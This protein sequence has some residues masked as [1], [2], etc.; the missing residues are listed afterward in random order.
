MPEGGLFHDEGE[1]TITTTQYSNTVDTWN[2][3][4]EEC[5][6]ELAFQ[7]QI[8]NFSGLGSVKCELQTAIGTTEPAE[9]SA[10]WQTIE[11]VPEKHEIDEDP[12]LGKT[13]FYINQFGRYLRVK[14]TIIGTPTVTLTIKYQTKGT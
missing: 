11:E 1:I 9:D 2:S 5:D 7:C 6:R 12:R 10:D 3:T 4:S 13:F 8:T 14:M